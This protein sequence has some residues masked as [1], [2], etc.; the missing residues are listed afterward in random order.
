VAGHSEDSKKH[1]RN[2]THSRKKDEDLA[3]N[4]RESGPK[5]TERKDDKQGTGE[6]ISKLQPGVQQER[7]QTKKAL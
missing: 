3:L 6:A 1:G 2:M 5:N 7:K 4:K